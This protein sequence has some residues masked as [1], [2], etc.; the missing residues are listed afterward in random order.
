MSFSAKQTCQ[1]LSC[2]AC[3][4]QNGRHVQVEKMKNEKF[5]IKNYEVDVIL[6]PLERTWN[7][8]DILLI[9]SHY[10]L[11]FWHALQNISWFL[12]KWLS[13]QMK[14]IF[15]IGLLAWIIWIEALILAKTILSMYKSTCVFDIGDISLC[16]LYR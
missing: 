5:W 1:W 8:T 10:W 12:S 7:V 6:F 16:F 3:F 15:K 4:I 14:E 11:Y 2:Y 9:W 13:F